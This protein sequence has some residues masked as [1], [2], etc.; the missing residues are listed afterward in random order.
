MSELVVGEGGGAR[1]GVVMEGLT[2]GTTYTVSVAAINGAVDG[3][4][5]GIESA[6]ATAL[7]DSSKYW[8]V[9]EL[10]HCTN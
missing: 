6:T 9:M 8:M 3:D 5:V 4:G 1:R 7:T 2:P 10:S